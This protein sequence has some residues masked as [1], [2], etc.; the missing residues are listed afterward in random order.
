MKKIFYLTTMLLVLACASTPELEKIAM[1]RMPKALEKAME[2]ELSLS[3]GA[4]IVSPETIYSCDSICMIHF[5]AV[6]RDS[7][8]EEFRFP[9]R[10]VLV[11]DLFMSAATG[12]PV[13]SEIVTGVSRMD[14][15]EINDLKQNCKENG[16]Q[17]FEFYS[18]AADPISKDD[19]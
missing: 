18:G 3:G 9:V 6:A 7:L 14:R 1:R 13:Y 17:L 12:H 16:N 15:E 11:H 5:E 8:G 10:Y 2:K 4:E 19:L